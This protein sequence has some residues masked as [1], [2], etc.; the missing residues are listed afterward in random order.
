MS[1]RECLDN[2]KWLNEKYTIERL[3]TTDIAKLVSCQY[4]RVCRA[5]KEHGIHIRTPKEAAVRRKLKGFKNKFLRDKDWLYKRYIEEKLT[6]YE[7][8]KLASSNQR[9]V[10][11]ALGFHGI[12]TRT[13]SEAAVNRFKIRGSIKKESIRCKNASDLKL[14]ESIKRPVSTF[15]ELNNFDWLY[16]KYVSQLPNH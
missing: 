8:A 15:F 3:S 10:L 9:S 14:R 4:Q 12:K 2:K 5:L 6:S 16:Q 1:T 7:V 13:V 11:H